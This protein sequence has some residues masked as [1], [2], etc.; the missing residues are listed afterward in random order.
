MSVLW[1][2]GYI[3]NGAKY[4]FIIPLGPIIIR[5]PLWV[6][7]P[8]KDPFFGPIQKFGRDYRFALEL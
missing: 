1:V 7:F 6:T 2:V 3:W 5:Y 4:L 8:S